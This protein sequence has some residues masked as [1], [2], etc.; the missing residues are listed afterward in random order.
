[1]NLI[2]V[3]HTH[4]DQFWPTVGPMI[5]KACEDKASCGEITPDQVRMAIVRQEKHLLVALSESEEVAG[6]WTVEF[7]NYPNLRVAFV[8]ALGGRGVLRQDVVDQVKQW[9]KLM[10]ASELRCY[11]KDAQARLYGRVGMVKIY[12][13]LGAKL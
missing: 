2:L 10:G 12:D 1:M 11:A 13:V 7:L 6:A 4:V 5:A 8:G 3:P 9:C